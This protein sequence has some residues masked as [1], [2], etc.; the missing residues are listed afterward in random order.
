MVDFD[1]GLD[2]FP[3]YRHEAVAVNTPARKQW[4]LQKTPATGQLQKTLSLDQQITNSFF[5]KSIKFNY[6][7]SQLSIK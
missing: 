5:H 6:N 2:V 7:E 4:Q 3:N 1:V